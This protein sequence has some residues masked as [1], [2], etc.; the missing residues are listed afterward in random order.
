MGVTERV[1][2]AHDM[3]KLDLKQIK[4]KRWLLDKGTKI[5]RVEEAKEFVERLGLVSTLTNKHLPSLAEAIYTEDL[6][7]R[8]DADQRLWDF[9]HVLVT[10]KWAYY[11]RISGDHNILMSLK[12]LPHYLHLYPVPD[13]VQLYEQKL[14]SEMAKSVM[15]L[16]HNEGPLMT[17]QLREKMAL[18]SSP[19]K[20]KLTQALTELQRKSLICCSGKVTKDHY[21]WRFGIWAPVDKWMPRRVKMRARALSDEEARRKIIEKYIYA[22]TKTTPDAIAR[23]FN[24]P[25]YEVKSIVSTMIDKELV[26]SYNHLGEQ[27]LFKGN[28]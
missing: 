1:G 13:Y 4:R 6:P 27:Y 28:L 8:F 16:L 21:R 10:R 3:K 2:V 23:F 18:A 9:V 26:S 20:K 14:L 17:G 22:T 15:D 7:G 11:G 25:L 5:F 19:E 12:L 24:W